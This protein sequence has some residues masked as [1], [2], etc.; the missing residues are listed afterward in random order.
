MYVCIRYS[1]EVFVKYHFFKI[2]PFLSKSF[3]PLMH[4]TFTL[5]AHEFLKRERKSFL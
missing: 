4:N 2:N 3:Y 1:G 5:V